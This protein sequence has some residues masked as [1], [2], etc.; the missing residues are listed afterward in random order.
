[1]KLLLTFAVAATGFAETHRFE[2]KE[3][4]NTSPALTH[5]CFVSNPVT[6]W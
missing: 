6:M 1:M 4:Y 5:P 3:F 2:P